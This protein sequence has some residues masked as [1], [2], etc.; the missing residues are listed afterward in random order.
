MLGALSLVN[1]SH[2]FRACTATTAFG[3]IVPLLAGLVI[4][5]V[6][7]V[8]LHGSGPD[9]ANRRTLRSSQCPACGSPVIDE[10][11]LCPN[12]GTFLES[13]SAAASNAGVIEQA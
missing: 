3:W 11:R 8:L 12:C 10:W 2:G 7:A 6:S 9:Y 1:G 13:T 4:G 5:G